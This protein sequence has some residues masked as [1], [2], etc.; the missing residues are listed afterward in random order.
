MNPQETCRHLLGHLSDYIDGELENQALCRE[1]EQHLQ[2]CENCQVV[3]DTLQQTVRLYQES[4]RE[5]E[6]PDEVRTR[7]FKT[8]HLEEFQENQD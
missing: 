7:L 8:L 1:I 2:D 4:A 6:I 3:V 5:T